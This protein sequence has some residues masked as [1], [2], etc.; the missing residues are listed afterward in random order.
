MRRRSNVWISFK[1][2]K[3]NF[4]IFSVPIHVVTHVQSFQKLVGR[5]THICVFP[6]KLQSTIDVPLP[7]LC[8]YVFSCQYNGLCQDYVVDLVYL[9]KVQI[10]ASPCQF[11]VILPLENILK[12]HKHFIFWNPCMHFLA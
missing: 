9:N 4:I 3:A 12:V 8:H 11:D 5:L 7:N 1:L 10:R 6:S 2:C